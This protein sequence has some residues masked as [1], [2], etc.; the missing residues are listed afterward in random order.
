MMYKNLDILS[1]LETDV[2]SV[3]KLQK[4]EKSINLKK[5]KKK[6]G[7]TEEQIK[8]SMKKHKQKKFKKQ[9]LRRHDKDILMYA[10]IFVK[11]R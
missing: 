2:E 11:P 5:M 3:I 7:Q 4:P 1:Q 8:F 10:E 9:P 6:A